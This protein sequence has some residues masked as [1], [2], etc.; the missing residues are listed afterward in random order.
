MKQ[1]KYI[2]GFFNTFLKRILNPVFFL[3][4]PAF[5]FFLTLNNCTPESCFEETNSAVKILFYSDATNDRDTPDSLT[6]YGIGVDSIRL[7]NKK[8]GV[9]P[10]LL[11][12]DAADGQSVF[13]IRING[14]ADTITFFNY[15]TFPHLVSRECG[16]SF[17]HLLIDTPL[18]TRNIIKDLTL[19][20]RNVTTLNEENISLYY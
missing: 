12:L 2:S 10:A 3:I 11:P 19:K 16:Y 5:L 4:V 13:V 20:N 18:Y 7:Y 17:Y 8:S 6:I 9:Q 15:T 14:I 1:K